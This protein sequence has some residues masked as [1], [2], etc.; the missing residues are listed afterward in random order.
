M[1]GEIPDVAVRDEFLALVLADPDLLDLAFAAVVA[2]WEAEPPRPPNRT[3]VAIAQLPSPQVRAWR[4]NDGRL[5][6]H[7]WLRSTPRPK[8]ARSPPKLVRGC[9]ADPYGGR[10]AWVE[11]ASRAGPSSIRPTQEQPIVSETA[12]K[13]AVVTFLR[14]EA[15]LEFERLRSIAQLSPAECETDGEPLDTASISHPGWVQECFGSLA[16]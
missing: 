10:M 15:P 16:S 14:K 2:S 8:V 6:W 12:S 13:E 7:R 9:Q 4:A 1:V 11:P 3:L 5:C